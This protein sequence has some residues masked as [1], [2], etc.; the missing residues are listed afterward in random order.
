MHAIILNSKTPFLRC[1]KVALITFLLASA[2]PLSGQAQGTTNK[3]P[4]LDKPQLYK[5]KQLNKKKKPGLPP[6]PKTYEGTM[7]LERM[8][9]II[10]RLDPAAKAIRKGV[11]QFII[12]KVPV[13]IVT[14]EKNDRMRILVSIRPAGGLSREVL[15]RIAQANFD[16][17]LDA[18]YAVARNVL[19]ATFIHPLRALH[20]KQF[21]SGIGQTVNLALTFGS[22]YSSGLLIFGGGDSQDI[23]RRQLIDKLLKKGV[24]I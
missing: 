2:S 16:S 12:E 1:V 24:P 21:I 10:T 7:T 15:A 19:W 8:N 9:T 14:D 18:R 20:D 6:A 23:I 22:T 13:L 4:P 17:A 11:W 3:K 5:K